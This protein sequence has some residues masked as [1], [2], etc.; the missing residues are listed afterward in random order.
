MLTRW[1]MP[2]DLIISRHAEERWA[3]RFPAF[4]LLEERVRQGGVVILDVELEVIY[5]PVVAPTCER[6]ALCSRQW[7]RICTR[8]SKFI[9]TVFEVSYREAQTFRRVLLLSLLQPA[10]A[11]P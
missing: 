10:T 3:E 11:H 6:D 7:A 1:D 4:G 2:S 9:T 8:R 5:F